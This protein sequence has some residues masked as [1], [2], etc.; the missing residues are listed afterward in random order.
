MFTTCA[1]TV[2]NK[3]YPQCLPICKT[4][5]C[6]YKND[7]RYKYLFITTPTQNDIIGRKCVTTCN[8]QPQTYISFTTT[9]FQRKQSRH[10]AT[11]FFWAFFL[12]N[13]KENQCINEHTAYHSCYQFPLFTN[14]HRLSSSFLSNKRTAFLKTIHY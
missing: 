4:H 1:A 3:I 5:H 12:L 7:E 13:S 9:R 2:L 8:N 14:M 11:Y 6:R 10:R